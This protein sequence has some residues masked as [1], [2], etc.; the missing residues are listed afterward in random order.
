MLCGF[1]RKTSVYVFGDAFV[2]PRFAKKAL[3]AAGRKALALTK[4]GKPRHFF[5]SF[6]LRK[7]F[8]FSP[9]RYF[10]ISPRRNA[11]LSLKQFSVT[12]PR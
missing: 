3:S 6:S 9:A 5:S 4:G 12:P 1:F 11:G 2:K 8:T 10:S 7:N